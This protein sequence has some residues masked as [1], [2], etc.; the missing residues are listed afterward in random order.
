M[1]TKAPAFQFYPGD[2]QRDA[3]LQSCSISARGLWIEMICIMH[4]GEPYG[5]LSIN[6]NP[7]AEP[8]LARL[9][10]S[11][12]KEIK[13]LLAELEHA[14][15]FQRDDNGT[16]I[17]RRMVKDEAIRRARASGG[18]LGGNPALT[19]KLAPNHSDT[20]KD[21]SEVETKV[22]LP[23]NLPP[24]PSS[25]SSSSSSNSLS[26]WWE[27]WKAHLRQ[28][29]NYD[30]GE[31]EAMTNQYELNRHSEDEQVA[32]IRFS[33]QKGAK[34]LILNGDHKPRPPKVA[35]GRGN[36]ANTAELGI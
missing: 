15:V 2:W 25:S 6:G 9:V 35:S 33:I 17:S 28:K 36:R 11:N 7:V 34:N 32:I 29:H 8:A 16:I 13:P 14:G 18:K 10:G 20:S 26:H 5:N 24:T 1:K 27:L 19:G 30:L 22:I 23:A 21:G 12:S 4:Q 3:A 31:I